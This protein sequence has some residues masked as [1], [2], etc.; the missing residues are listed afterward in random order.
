MTPMCNSTTGLTV[1]WAVATV[2]CEGTN[3]T[4]TYI[5][6]ETSAEY[7]TKPA[8]WEYC[9]PGFSSDTIYSVVQITQAGYDALGSKDPNTLYVIVG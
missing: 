8:T 1:G 2:D 7:S 3:I 4:L 5:D 9:R 6:A